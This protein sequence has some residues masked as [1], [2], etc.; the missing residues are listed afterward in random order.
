MLNDPERGSTE[1]MKVVQEILGHKK[2]STTMNIYA[3]LTTT[4]KKNVID[5]LPFGKSV[6]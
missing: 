1:K 4:H 5:N 6:K 2:I 3:H